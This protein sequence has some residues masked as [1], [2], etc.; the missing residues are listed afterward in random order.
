LSSVRVLYGRPYLNVTLFYT[1]VSQLHGNPAF[2]TEQMGGE[3]LAFTPR[4]RTLGAVALLRAGLAIMREWRRVVREGPS[5]F[6]AMKAV[7]E[8][9]RSEHVQHFSMDELSE[10]LDG[11][12]RWLDAHE[13]TYG[14]AGGVAQ[15]L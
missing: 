9:Y 5:T 3:P 6:E 2:L 8:T 7:A 13:L 14:I 15:S 1:L 11:L 12:G 10:K 4:V